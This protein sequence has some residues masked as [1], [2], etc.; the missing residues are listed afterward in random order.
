MVHLLPI[1]DSIRSDR[2]VCCSLRN[3]APVAP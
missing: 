1:G 3:E 2:A